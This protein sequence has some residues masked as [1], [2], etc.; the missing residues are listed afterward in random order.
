MITETGAINSKSSE[1]SWK[2]DKSC[3]VD[4]LREESE[5]TILSCV[6]VKR[7]NLGDSLYRW[8]VHIIDSERKIRHY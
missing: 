3:F 5:K 7:L 6:S 2:C 8:D 4:S 1:E